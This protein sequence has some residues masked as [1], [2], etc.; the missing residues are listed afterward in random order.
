MEKICVFCGANPGTDPI[1]RKIAEDLG[2]YLSEENIELIYGGSDTGLM[3]A[4]A[5]S[6]LDNQGNVT[7]VI[8]R[9]L[10]RKMIHKNSSN[11]IIVDDMSQRKQRMFDLSDAFITLPG[12]YGT[13]DEIFEMLTLSKL[14]YHAKP[15]GFLNV[16]GFYDSLLD[17]LDLAS[18]QGFITPSERSMAFAADNIGDL[19]KRFQN[20]EGYQR[21]RF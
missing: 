7:A 12:G 15:C 1:Y 8:P 21:M 5:N 20:M 19:L 6:V 17:F 3:G 18:R 14:G 11:V 16:N 4:V 9:D 13:L 10:K 2:R